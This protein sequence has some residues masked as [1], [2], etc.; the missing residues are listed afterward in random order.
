MDRDALLRFN[1]QDLIHEIEK[2]T[3]GGEH[4]F[5]REFA[6]K[7]FD[8]LAEDMSVAMR[9]VRHLQEQ[10]ACQHPGQSPEDARR[11][12]QNPKFRT[13][14]PAN[15][16]RSLSAMRL[17]LVDEIAERVQALFAPLVKLEIVDAELAAT[18]ETLAEVERVRE[19]HRSTGVYSGSADFL[20]RLF[21]NHNVTWKELE[22]LS[23]DD[24]REIA[25]IA[26]R[27]FRI[28][29]GQHGAGRL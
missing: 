13:T 25:D 15:A 24:E 20:S 26:L 21:A 18:R 12:L 7:I 2:L 22:T 5:L 19:V 3:S 29:R 16:A 11:R 1:A 14:Y 4:G 23:E 28:A 9:A 6:K 10:H 27:R 8:E 17:E